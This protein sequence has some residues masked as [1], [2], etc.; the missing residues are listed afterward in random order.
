MKKTAD[1][2]AASGA[3]YVQAIQNFMTTAAKNGIDIGDPKVVLQYAQ[4]AKNPD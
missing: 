3:S 1:A 4:M 2:N